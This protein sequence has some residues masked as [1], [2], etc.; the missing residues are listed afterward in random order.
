MHSAKPTLYAFLASVDSMEKAQGAQ[1]SSLSRAATSV[2]QQMST[3]SGSR[4]VLDALPA[5]IAT[6]IMMA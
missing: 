1:E 6:L 5:I 2:S 4:A 3:E